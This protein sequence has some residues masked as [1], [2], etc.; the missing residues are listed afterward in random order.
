MFTDI[1]YTTE[2][3]PSRNRSYPIALGVAGFGVVFACLLD[4]LP[5]AMISTAIPGTAGACG[6]I[7]L[8]YASLSSSQARGLDSKAIILKLALLIWAY[9]L[10]SEQLFDRFSDP[11][12]AESIHTYQGN[13]APEAYGETLI[14]VVSFLCLIFILLPRLS[15]LGRL[16]TGA[17]KW[18]FCF[19]MLCAFS[20][21]YAP[22]RMYTLGWT[23]KLLLVALLIGVCSNTIDKLGDITA[24][25][26]CTL[27]AFVLLTLLPVLSALSNPTTAF[28]SEGRLDANPDAL[29]E[30][31][32]SLML[33]ALMLYSMRK[34]KTRGAIVFIAALVM[35]LS[36][37]K[38]GI[39][40]GIFSAAMFFLLQKKVAS[41][42]TVLG[43]VIALGTL[44]FTLVSPLGRYVQSY[45][46]LSTATGRTEIWTTAI[47]AI[48][49]APILGHGYLASHFFW[50]NERNRMA[51]A[52]HLHNSFLDV[53]YNIGAVGLAL[54][55]L[56]HGAIIKNL[57]HSISRIA[58]H[59][60]QA[61]PRQLS[62]LQKAYILASGSLALYANLFINGLLGPSFGGRATS[63]FELFLALVMLSQTLAAWVDEHTSALDTKRSL[64][65]HFAV[66]I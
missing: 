50:V 35:L 9:V 20:A 3:T 6:L 64:A 37:G 55:L 29:S 62:E 39:F 45:Q 24:F 31:A 53:L 11:V 54:I 42:L 21:A 32:G 25:F 22:A 56:M 33:M 5:R 57:F 52:G 66:T 59:R 13:F 41:T 23:F 16:F 14:W 63:S 7:I 1:T 48:R 47:P 27:W 12:G 8:L 10:I 36:L 43:G 44:M 15:F 65:G 4:S 28:D 46:G 60:K 19:V 26:N 58:A 61:T 49:A 40:A 51:R 38:T 2:Q 17:Q 18:I 34:S 30:R